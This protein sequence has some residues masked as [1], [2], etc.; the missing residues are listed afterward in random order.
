MRGGSDWPTGL[1]WGWEVGKAAWDWA[2][3]GPG[4]GAKMGMEDGDGD[5]AWG[6][7]IISMGDGALL[8]GKEGAPSSVHA[9]GSYFR[10]ESPA[11]TK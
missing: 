11:W 3:A 9:T 2:G 5:G 1:G 7:R 4:L 6:M 8:L 10:L